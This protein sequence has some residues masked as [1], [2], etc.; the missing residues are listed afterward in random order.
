MAV[1]A[2][3]SAHLW[4]GALPLLDKLLREDGGCRGRRFNV[5]VINLAATGFADDSPKSRPT[6]SKHSAAT[7]QGSVPA[8]RDLRSLLFARAQQTARAADSACNTAVVGVTGA[9]A[10]KAGKA[11]SMRAVQTTAAAAAA[12]VTAAATPTTATAATATDDS[13][14]SEVCRLLEISAAASRELLTSSK[15]DVAKAVA[16][17]FSATAKRHRSGTASAAGGADAA[18]KKQKRA[19]M[20]TPKLKPAKLKPAKLKAARS[21]RGGARG[22]GIAAYFT[23]A[24]A[25]ATQ[26]GRSRA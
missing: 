14:V 24:P 2:A 23:A 9:A 5:T 16:L 22:G 17:H 11:G 3:R 26:G 4:D 21:K 25:F 15:G 6:A 13:A 1:R 8:V 20:A 12:A 19:P 7:A 18:W 10:A